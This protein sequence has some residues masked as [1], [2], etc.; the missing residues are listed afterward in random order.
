MKAIV[1]GAASGIGRELTKIL[2]REGYE[3]GLADLKKES[4]FALQSEIPA[5]SYIRQIDVSSTSEARS[6]VNSLIHEM[7][8]VDLVILSAGVA[9]VNPHLEWEK[10]KQIIDVNVLGFCAMANL[11]MNYF[12]EQGR[13]HLVGISSIAAIRGRGAYSASKAFIS[14]Y[15]EGLRHKSAREKKQ[16]IV[17]DIKPGFIDTPLTRRW[18]KDEKL[19][20]VIPVEKASEMIYKVIQ[21]KK[22][23][24]YLSF[25]WAIIAWIMKCLPR[26]I[27]DRIH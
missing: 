7:G 18:G 23:H 24:A 2:A 12:L 13:G 8:G 3:V 5:K 25:R 11:F 19:F 27:Y 4:L 26:F 22:Y 20:W 6:E 21:K 10:D 9:Y 1:I 15:L 14:N 17:T 16:I